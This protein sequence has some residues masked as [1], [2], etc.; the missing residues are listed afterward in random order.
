MRNDAS[1]SR[2][3]FVS[4]KYHQPA[5]AIH[6][7][8][9]KHFVHLVNNTKQNVSLTFKL[10]DCRRE[11]SFITQMTDISMQFSKCQ[12]RKKR[13][14]ELVIA[15]KLLPI[16]FDSVKKFPVEMNC[17]LQKLPLLLLLEGFFHPRYST[18]ILMVASD[19]ITVQTQGV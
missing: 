7:H 4:L 6:V 1:W 9:Q 10:M 8:V 2:L 11:I 5:C 19:D 17:L 18:F 3:T 12:T 13:L 14:I 16:K 15:V